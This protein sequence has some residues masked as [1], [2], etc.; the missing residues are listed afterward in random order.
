M[1]ASHD[2]YANHGN[3]SSTTVISVLDRLRDED[4]DAE[5]PDGQPKE[6]VV[7]CAF[8]PGMVVETCLLRRRQHGAVNGNGNS[9]K[10]SMNQDL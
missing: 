9:G 10:T 3:S 8:G 6:H 4:M 1:R 5:A 7:G 2:I